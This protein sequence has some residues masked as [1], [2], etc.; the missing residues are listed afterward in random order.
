LAKRFSFGRRPPSG[1]RSVAGV[2]DV[3]AWDLQSGASLEFMMPA[4]GRRVPSVVE[5]VVD[6]GAHGTREWDRKNPGRRSM[7]PG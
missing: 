1:R 5:G 2:S 3:E 7:A 6:N 4:G